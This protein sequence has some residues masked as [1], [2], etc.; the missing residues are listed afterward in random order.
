MA[1]RASA[2][3]AAK[4]AFARVDPFAGLVAHSSNVFSKPEPMVKGA[5][6]PEPIH[7][8]PQQREDA[9]KSYFAGSQWRAGS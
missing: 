1:K 8:E 2:R 5:D 9:G 7:R 4:R 6:E 3:A